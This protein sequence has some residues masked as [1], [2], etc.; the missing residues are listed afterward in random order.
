MTH[1]HIGRL[2]VLAA[3]LLLGAAWE[4]RADLTYE[5]SIDTSSLAG[6]PSGYIDF[7][8]NQSANAAQA[9][10]AALHNFSGGGGTLDPLN[11]SLMGDVAGDLGAGTLTLHNTPGFNDA[12]LGFT[13]GSQIV[14]DVTLSGAALN[15][16]SG[17]VSEGS[18]FAFSLYKNDA[19][20]ALSTSADGS[21]VRLDVVPGTGAVNVTSSALFTG[22]PMAHADPVGPATVTPEPSTFLPA[23]A[24]TTL[25]LAYAARRR[26]ASA[27]R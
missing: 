2:S 9:V 12:F 14:F 24:A 13:F 21:L 6:G 19:M 15:S 5:I 17:A 22:G 4:A 10:T 7:Q 26:R 27:P 11:I 25:G 23:L 8:L 18:S 16:P 1:G 20:T 3:A